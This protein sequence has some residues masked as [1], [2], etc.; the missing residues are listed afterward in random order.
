VICTGGG[1]R[2]ITVPGSEL[3]A[4][5]NDAWE[6]KS[7]SPYM[8]V[9]GA[10]APGAHVASIFNLFGSKV[11]LFLTRRRLLLTEDEDMS[12]SVAQAFRE[13]GIDVREDFG[14]IESFEQTEAGI[15][16]T[17]RKGD[18]RE[19]AAASLAVSA[20]GWVANTEGLD[21]VNAE[22]QTDSRGF[23]KVDQFLQ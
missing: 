16:M 19:S 8:I 21:L 2:K 12:R 14:A 6:L 7:N 3:T 4:N 15:R 20:I 18:K 1:S 5:H 11:Q 9:I 22:V 17:F 13:S 23:V 10:G